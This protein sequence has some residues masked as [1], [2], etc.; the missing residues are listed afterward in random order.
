M[1]RVKRYQAYSMRWDNQADDFVFEGRLL[2]YN[3]WDTLEDFNDWL[4]DEN[5]LSHTSEIYLIDE[6]T[7][8]HYKMIG[9]VMPTIQ[10]LTFA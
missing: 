6:W 8:E 2:D 1:E 3:G 9:R 5:D 4:V 7:G 10:T